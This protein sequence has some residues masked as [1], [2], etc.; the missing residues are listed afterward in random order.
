MKKLIFTTLSAMVLSSA[1]A[2]APV[3]NGSP[4]FECA[5][6]APVS[7]T[8]NTS[9]YGKTYSSEWYEPYVFADKAGASASWTRYVN[10]LFPDSLVKYIDNTGALSYM[11]GATNI[12]QVL[13]PKDDNIDLT[14]NPAIKLSKFNSYTLDSVYFYY[15]YVRN[16]DSVPDG[17]GGNLPVVDTLFIYYFTPAGLKAYTLN[18]TPAEVCAIP[19]FDVP[20]RTPK[21]AALKQTIL[22]TRN[23]STS[24][25]TSTSTGAPESSWGTKLYMA[26]VPT[27]VSVAGGNTGQNIV[28]F[29][30]K[31]KPGHS[32]DTGSVMIYQNA[33]A[34]LPSGTKRANYFGYMFYANGQQAPYP[35]QVAQTKFYTNSL[36]AGKTSSYNTSSSSWS[37]F[38]PGNAYYAHEYVING[39]K[40]TTN[41]LGINDIKNDNFAMS[42]VYP[43]PA[44]IGQNTYVAFNL[45]SSAKVTVEVYNL[46]GQHV[47]TVANSNFASGENSIELNTADLNAGIYFVNMTVNGVTQTKKL[48]VVE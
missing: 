44:T 34:P 24:A 36:V 28:G 42:S 12:G 13:D 32:Y 46:M 15:L 35:T 23:D 43:N 26:K 3:T 4:R 30:L 9:V 1:F 20:T 45:K 17:V 31:F 22:L 37:G 33:S 16:V 19:D 6:K 29:S 39:F 5:G 14:D 21:A 40:L 25:F 38:V 48:T 18:G 41:T 10:F 8:Q 11:P 47:K 7:K 2:Q 27:G